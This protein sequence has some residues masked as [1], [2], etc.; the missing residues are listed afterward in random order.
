MALPVM[1]AFESVIAEQHDL[2][3]KGLVT[4]PETFSKLYLTA[5]RAHARTSALIARSGDDWLPMPDWRLDRRVIR[6]ALFLRHR[7]GLAPQEKVLLCAP[8]G[9]EWVIADLAIITQGAI[10]VAVD[11]TASDDQLANVLAAARPSVVFVSNEAAWTRLAGLTESRVRPA[12]VVVFD[13]PSTTG[14]TFEEALDLAGTLDTPEHAA[15]FRAGAHELTAEIPALWHLRP[16][17]G[18]ASRWDRLTHGAIID[19]VRT[20]WA[21]YP[22]ESPGVAYVA[23]RHITLGTR[24]ALY[25]LIGDGSTTIAFGT[26]GRELEEVATLRPWRIVTPPEVLSTL[27]GLDSQRHREEPG[28]GKRS[29]WVTRLLKR[30]LGVQTT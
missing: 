15:S 17:S 11:P 5:M 26:V 24:L 21:R 29:S 13:G 28:P 4:L 8:L 2:G 19:A 9:C 1:T 30:T 10:S 23:D 3:A 25:S 18:A 22:A 7:I 20:L 27:E 6:I 16:E 12:A 14:Q